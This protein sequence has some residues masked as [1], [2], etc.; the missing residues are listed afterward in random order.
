[1]CA[2]YR[3]GGTTG[4]GYRNATTGRQRENSVTVEKDAEETNWEES[5][6]NRADGHTAAHVTGQNAH[7]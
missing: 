3:Y 7:L 2:P 1:M 4:K 5:T 6:R